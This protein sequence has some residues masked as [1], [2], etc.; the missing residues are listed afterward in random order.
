MAAEIYQGKWL[1]IKEERNNK[2]FVSTNYRLKVH[3]DREID[4]LYFNLLY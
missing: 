3:E 4:E 1:A 2:Q